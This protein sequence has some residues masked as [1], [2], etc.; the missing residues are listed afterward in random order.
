[1]DSESF[2]AIEYRWKMY[3][4]LM[5]GVDHIRHGLRCFAL[6]CIEIKENIENAKLFEN[7]NAFLH[8]IYCI[9]NVLVCEGLHSR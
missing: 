9:C 8:Y 7:I 1:M 5:S 3:L 6:F 4:Q 2:P